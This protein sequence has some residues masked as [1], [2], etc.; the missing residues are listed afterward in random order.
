[1]IT[2]NKNQQ[3]IYCED[4]GEYRRHCEICDKLFKE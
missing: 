2:E 3:A 1:M 4:N